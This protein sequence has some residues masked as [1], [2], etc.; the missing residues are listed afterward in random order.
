[1]FWSD[2]NS[3]LHG[4]LIEGIEVIPPSEL[5]KYADECILVIATKTEFF[6]QIK[7]V[8]NRILF[9]CYSTI[10]DGI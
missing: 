1:M 9:E 10:I 6:I 2:N 4:N 3:E 5:N 7:Y 8:H